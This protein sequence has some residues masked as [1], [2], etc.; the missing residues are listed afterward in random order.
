MQGKFLV[1][2]CILTLIQFLTKIDPYSF[3]RASIILIYP[4]VKNIMTY[5]QL[6]NLKL[7]WKTVIFNTLMGA[8]WLFYQLAGLQFAV[9]QLQKLRVLQKFPLL[10]DIC[11][12]QPSCNLFSA[13]SCPYGD[14][15]YPSQQNQLFPTKHSFNNKN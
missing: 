3:Y 8:L 1:R 9:W 12:K 11:H 6:Q 7:I 13:G 14:P 15:Y 2:Y 10:Q 5:M 4:N